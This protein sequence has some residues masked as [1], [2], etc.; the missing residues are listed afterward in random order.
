[1]ACQWHF[2]NQ[3][4][5]EVICKADLIFILWKRKNFLPARAWIKE[6]MMFGFWG[7]ALLCFQI[8]ICSS[9]AERESVADVVTSFWVQFWTPNWAEINDD[10]SHINCISKHTI[11][12][13]F[14]IS[15]GTTSHYQL[16]AWKIPLKAQRI[17]SAKLCLKSVSI[18]FFCPLKHL[19]TFW[20]TKQDLGTGLRVEW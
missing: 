20:K 11:F 16:M 7:K 3:I 5:L 10:T 17:V 19:N 18:F 12:F 9:H 2:D 14:K 6:V 1:M 15:L 13:P 8:S 4:I